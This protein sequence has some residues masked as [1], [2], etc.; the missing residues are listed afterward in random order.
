MLV[1]LL[2]IRDLTQNLNQNLN[3]GLSQNNWVLHS[4]LIAMPKP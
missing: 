1:S 2:L 3:Q 4:G